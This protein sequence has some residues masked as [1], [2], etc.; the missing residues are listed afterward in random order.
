LSPTPI[1][2][3]KGKV[4][5]NPR[6]NIRSG[7]N[8]SYP[9][10]SKANYGEVVELIEK[11]N[12]WYKIKLSNGTIGWGSGDYIINVTNTSE[13]SNSNSNNSNNNSNSSDNSS[14]NNNQ[15][16]NNGDSGN[17]IKPPENIEKPQND[18][19]AV[20]KL[21]HDLIGTPYGWGGN[22]P[23]NFDCSGFTRYVYSNAEGKHIP[24]VSKEQANYG[25]EVNRESFL[26][27]DLVYFDTDG[28]GVINHT[29]IY[30]GNNEFIH[31]SGTPTNP[32]TVKKENLGTTYWTKVLVG[33]RRF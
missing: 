4:I 9:V 22:G 8:T 20:V 29:G 25:V 3:N 16:N 27:G 7:P 24:R 1:Q 31:A 33:A 5:A 2:G 15:G 30:V 32:D 10:K 28:D 19:E 12:G 13:N 14:N 21:S 17:E 26:P 11:S 6:L 18:R 23:N